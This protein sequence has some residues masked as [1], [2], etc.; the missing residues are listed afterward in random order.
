[1]LLDY[2]SP[3]H[4]FLLS[5]LPVLTCFGQHPIWD[6]ILTFERA[7][8]A[9]Y[10]HQLWQA[11]VTWLCLTCRA[12]SM[13]IPTPWYIHPC[14]W[15]CELM[16]ARPF[17]SPVTPNVTQ[18]QLQILH[19]LYFKSSSMIKWSRMLPAEGNSLTLERLDG[20]RKSQIML[21]TTAEFTPGTK[22]WS[23]RLVTEVKWKGKQCPTLPDRSSVC[24]DEGYSPTLNYSPLKG[25]RPLGYFLSWK[26]FK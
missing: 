12:E 21:T 19:L 9:T 17:A 22:I 13:A 26:H 14:P 2:N 10:H 5:T 18:A 24:C 25:L 8:F 3:I 11:G 23:G 16:A 4:N 1:M 7:S 20:L 6:P 15:W